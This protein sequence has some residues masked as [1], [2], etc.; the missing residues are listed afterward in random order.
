MME[1]NPGEDSD[2]DEED[3]DASTANGSAGQ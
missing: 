1:L 2:E 3:D